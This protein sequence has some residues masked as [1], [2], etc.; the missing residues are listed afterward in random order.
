MS[1]AGIAFAPL[2]VLGAKLRSGATSSVELTKF[3]LDRL[4]TFGPRYNC[5]ATLTRDRALKEAEARMSYVLARFGGHL[6][7]AARK[8]VRAEIDGLV[9]RAEALR[10]VPLDNGD[11]PFPVFRPYRAPLT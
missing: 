2:T 8:S 1:D 11:G 6:D 4:E 7:E 5:V 9:G 3:F 10:K